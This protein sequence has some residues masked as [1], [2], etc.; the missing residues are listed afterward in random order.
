MS[1]NLIRF[2]DGAAYERYMGPWSQAVGEV[3]LDWLALPVQQQWLDVGCGSGAFTELIVALCAPASVHGIDPAEAQ[4]AYARA[5]HAAGLAQFTLGDAMD[6]PF[7]D[8]A[9]D[10][11]VMPLVIFF[12]PDPVKG[13]AEMARAVRPGGM[14]AAYAWD[15][16]GGGSPYDALQTE[17]REMGVHFADP[18]SQ[19]AS[20]IDALQSLWQG[21]GLLAVETREIT[22]QRTFADFEA[23][24]GV[25]QGSPRVGS[26]I[27]AMP[28]AD[29]ARLQARMRERLQAGPAG[30]PLT[31]CARAHAV[32]GSVPQL[33]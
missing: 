33:V 31:Y 1:S 27:A 25:V 5:R 2:V 19:D 32:K 4:L 14:V 28:L 18:P 29:R 20:R 17:M 8:G 15:L 21:A 22:V 12:V 30:Q 7:Q 9:F 13:V 26:E 24:W 11:A 10:V 23:Y 6:L 16:C 3:F